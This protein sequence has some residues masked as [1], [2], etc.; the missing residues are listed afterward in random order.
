MDDNRLEMVENAAEVKSL[1]EDVTE[2]KQ[3]VKSVE[4][5]VND[6][7]VLLAGNYVTRKDFDKHKEAVQ[8]ALDEQK[9]ALELHKEK[10]QN[11]RRWWAIAIISGTGVLTSVI[12]VL[13]QI[14]FRSK[15][16]G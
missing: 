9:T 8:T 13:W 15:G 2:I 4:L 5:T 14:F 1:K 11:D 7:R 6:L 16:V 12:A 10:E 3:T